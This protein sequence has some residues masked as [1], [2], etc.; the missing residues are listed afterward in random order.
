MTFEPEESETYDP[1]AGEYWYERENQHSNRAFWMLS[2]VLPATAMVF[3]SV[4]LEA[5][6]IPWFVDLVLVIVTSGFLLTAMAGLIYGIWLAV[7]YK[8]PNPEV[9]WQ[10]RTIPPPPPEL[11]YDRLRRIWRSH[12]SWQPWRRRKSLQKVMDDLRRQAE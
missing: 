1:A 6:G 10:W 9:T 7:W 11:P 4:G 8:R 2:M 3:I 5:W 12:P